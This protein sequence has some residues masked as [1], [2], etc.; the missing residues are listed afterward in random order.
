MEKAPEKWC[1]SGVQARLNNMAINSGPV[2]GILGSNTKYA[3]K[4]FQAY[5]DLKKDGKPG[6]GETQP[7]LVDV[8]DKNTYT[9]NP[10]PKP[11]TGIPPVP[12]KKKLETPDEDIGHVA[13]CGD[14][15][16]FFNTLVVRP[17]YRI[18]ITLGDI[19][20]LFA[21]EP[22]TDLGRM[23]RFQV[24]GLYPFPLGHKVSTTANLYP[25]GWHHT[26][27]HVKTK[28]FGLADNAPDTD[29]DEQVA[30]WLKNA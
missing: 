10:A 3:V 5:F 16:D 29:V 28:V 24:L 26:L 11:A 21:Q 15:N 9:G 30:Q 23:A 1:I 2:D 18:S 12:E 22:D 19:E 17:E 7:K 8:H 27:K 25:K 6:Q 13:P 14:D 4:T 20:N